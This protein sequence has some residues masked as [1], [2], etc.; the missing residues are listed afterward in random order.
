MVVDTTDRH[1]SVEEPIEHCLA[2]ISVAAGGYLFLLII[3]PVII[4][5]CLKRGLLGHPRRKAQKLH[6]KVA[7]KA[8]LSSDHVFDSTSLSTSTTV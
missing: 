8:P 6:R 1:K 3:Y 5:V 2:V 7:T 4:C